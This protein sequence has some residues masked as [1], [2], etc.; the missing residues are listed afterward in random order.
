[1]KDNVL[2]VSEKFYSIQGEGRTVGTPAVFLRLAGCNLLCKSNDWV[3]DSI[4]VWQKGIPT[5][6]NEI[7]TG[8]LFE[9]LV[10]GAHL[11][12]TGGEPLLHQK[13]IVEYLHWFRTNFGWSPTVEIETNGTVI[14]TDFIME[15]VTYWN[16][17]PKLP[18]AGEPH[19]KRVNEV[20]LKKLNTDKT[21][22]KF[23]ISKEIDYIDLL[24]DYSHLID[25][26]K[27]WLMPAGATQDELN[28]SR[29][30]VVE[31]CKRM[32]HHYTDRTHI[33]I[34]NKKTGV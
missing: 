17:S 23:V 32:Y 19:V 18:N 26:S 8:E 10:N 15:Y 34:W 24:Q 11:I 20:A 14:P 13:N 9:A 29:L 31:L 6:F 22:Y 12:I 7:L 25:M 1:M 30:T 2:I 3:C 16:V 5:P 27:V 21:I 28:S 33:V 4:E